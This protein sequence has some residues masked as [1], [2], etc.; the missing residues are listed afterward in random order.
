RSG[1]GCR[2]SAP[3]NASDHPRCSTG[4]RTR[5]SPVR[6][7]GFPGT[8]WARCAPALRS[9]PARHLRRSGGPCARWRRYGCSREPVHRVQSCVELQ[10]FL[11]WAGNDGLAV[12]DDDGALDQARVIDHGLNQLGLAQVEVVQ[13]EFLVDILSPT[14]QVPGVHAQLLQQVAEGGAVRGCL[15][16]LGD[17]QQ[18]TVLLQQRELLGGL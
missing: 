2:E 18:V 13:L 6:W 15:N 17:L 1:S 9:R 11:R 12:T 7:R 8:P 16:E 3:S 14:L 5:E 4:R 10:D